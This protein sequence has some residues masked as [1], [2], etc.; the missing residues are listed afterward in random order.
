L[1][2]FNQNEA[3]EGDSPRIAL[4]N[5][6]MFLFDEVNLINNERLILIQ[7]YTMLLRI[8]MEQVQESDKDNSCG[9]AGNDSQ[10]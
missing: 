2:N 5:V 10:M 7:T 4:S 1:F 8:Q 9:A 6:N 3:E